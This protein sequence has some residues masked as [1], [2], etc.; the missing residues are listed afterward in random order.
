[1]KQQLERFPELVPFHYPLH[2]QHHRLAAPSTHLF[3]HQHFEFNIQH[4]L[5]FLLV[6]GTVQGTKDKNK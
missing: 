6:S 5:K 3:I 4:I 1:M 2:S